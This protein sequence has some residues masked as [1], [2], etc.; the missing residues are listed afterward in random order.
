MNFNGWRVRDTQCL[1]GGPLRVQRGDL[2]VGCRLPYRRAL[3]EVPTGPS[4][5]LDRVLADGWRVE[6]LVRSEIPSGPPAE[7]IRLGDFLLSMVVVRALREA[8]EIAGVEVPPMSYTGTRGRLMRRCEIPVTVEEDAPGCM[9]TAKGRDPIRIEVRPVRPPRWVGFPRYADRMTVAMPI[10]HDP[11]GDLVDV[12]AT[13]PLRLYLQMEQD[14][15]VRLPGSGDIVPRYRSDVVEPD[16]G[17]VVFVATTSSPTGKDYGVDGFA[18][19]ARHLLMR[20]GL[21]LRFTLLTNDPDLP[22]VPIAPGV[23]MRV[24]CGMD[25]A[26]CVDLFGS[27]ELVI[28][29]DTGLTHLAA[30]SVRPDGGGPHVVGLYNIFSPLKWNTGSPR[31]HSVS[32]P[33]AQMLAL[34][35]IDIYINQSG[36]YIDPS[37]W[38]EG[39]DL[40][41]APAHIV[42]EFAANCVGWM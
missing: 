3:G 14:L 9:V 31:H 1:R 29:N 25:A 16:A 6:F 30:L 24:V 20:T 23:R 7:P 28:G 21:D 39:A 33:L 27:A 32:T 34:A 8:A 18:E 40:S 15:G 10:W 41:T 4:E 36:F 38:A 2:P 19:V 5:L 13:L 42:A 22:P 17:H 35:D 37:L 12:H 11:S 26:D